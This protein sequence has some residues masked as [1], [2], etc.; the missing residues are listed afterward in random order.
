MAHWHH[1]THLLPDYAAKVVV[2]GI[3]KLQKANRQRSKKD[4]QKLL[5]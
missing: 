2:M 3:K 4:E 5:G 1:H